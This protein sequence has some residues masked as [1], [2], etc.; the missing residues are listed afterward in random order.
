[1]KI[2]FVDLHAQYLTIKD[3]IDSSISEVIATSSYIHG[4]FVEEFEN[5]FSNLLNSKFCISCANGTDAIYISLKTLGIGF[6]DEVITVAN[7]WISTSETISQT[8][9]TPVFV[10]IHPDYYTLNISQ[11]EKFITPK[12]K[13]VIPVH[14]FG[15]TVE[16][17]P[18][19]E[20]CNSKGLYLIEDCAQAHL[21]ECKG[22]KAGTMGIAGTFSFFPGKNLGAYGDAG[23]I[24]TDNEDFAKRARMFANHGSLSKHQ[25]EIEGINS[26]MDGI[27]AAV[28]N[29][30]IPY[31]E[32]WTNE[33]SNVASWYDAGLEDLSQIVT[34]I[35]RDSSRHAY[36]LY[37]VRVVDRDSL[38]SHLKSKGISTGIHYPSPLPTIYAFKYL[39]YTKED[40]PV[41]YSDRTQILSLPIYP[42]MNREKVD[43]VCKSIH[44][45]YE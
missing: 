9:A 10:D 20:L 35:I 38:I 40:F 1:M 42:E 6:G 27:Q 33:R 21:A 19:I 30:K 44:E 16:M 4:P 28:L 34:P 8:G 5:A 13:A 23:A 14:L 7:S 18:L 25:H 17:D 45:F 15:Q 2:N 43:Y 22:R 32:E 37:V 24:V 36:H 31:L 29:V 12:T 26:R 3:Q 41:A 39:G 11:L